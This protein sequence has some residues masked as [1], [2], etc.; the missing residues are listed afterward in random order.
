MPVALDELGRTEQL[1][2]A[3]LCAED[4][5]GEGASACRIRHGG[6]ERIAVAGNHINRCIGIQ[7]AQNLDQLIQRLRVSAGRNH[8]AGHDHGVKL[9]ISKRKADELLV[10]A[11]K[12]PLQV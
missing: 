3:L 10:F 6:G 4:P 1:C 7:F 2:A 8:V 5:R 9:R 12:Q 11:E